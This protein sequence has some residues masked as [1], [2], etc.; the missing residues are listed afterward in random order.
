MER[1][2]RSSFRYQN[3]RRPELSGHW[4]WLLALLPALGLILLLA[5]VDSL[6][7]ADPAP[8]APSPAVAAAPCNVSGFVTTDTTWGPAICDPY[9]VIGTIVITNGVTLTIEPGTMVKFNSLK[10]LTVQGTLVA[11]GAAANLIT[12]T[13]NVGQGKG[14]W[15]YIYF[16]DSS[17]DATFD[18]DGNYTG[19]SVIQYAVIE[20]AGGGEEG[21]A[22]RI[23]ASTPFVDHNTI[24]YNQAG[25]IQAGHV[26]GIIITNNLV[27]N[28]TGSGISVSGINPYSLTQVT[29]LNNTIISNT[30]SGISAYFNA[31][32]IGNNTIMGNTANNGGGLEVVYG[33]AIIN[34]NTITG[35]TASSGGGG[36]YT[37]FGTSTTISNNVI[38]GNTAAWGGGLFVQYGEH[39]ISNNSIT[40]NTG[41]YG[42]GIYS[43]D[44]T[45]VTIQNNTI[46][47]NT[48]YAGGGIDSDSNSA[49][50]VSDN[51]IISNTADDSAG[52]M[53]LM[54]FLSTYTATI[55]NNVIVANTAGQKH[56][57]GGIYLAGRCRPLINDNDL[58]GNLTGNPARFPN[59][60]YEGNVYSET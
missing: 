10:A 60:L 7:R 53:Y 22:L 24:Q 44:N 29:I 57:G 40:N 30:G 56:L 46:S 31:A 11:R 59:D 1:L 19:G 15:G 18:D 32:T 47:G 34:N 49:I 20:Y 9:V 16:T 36:I 6:A 13:S 2:L 55:N 41:Y 12:F 58:Y 48:A 25:G 45:S 35:N 28:N 52:G 37:T 42:G 43:A 38:A 5:G 23:E 27:S 50:I 33:T 54:C 4:P 26:D 3:C 51:T 39:T 8:T 14:D 17:A 21:G